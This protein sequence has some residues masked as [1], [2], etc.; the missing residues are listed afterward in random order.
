MFWVD[1]HGVALRALVLARA[2]RAGKLREVAR[3]EQ[4]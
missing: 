2:G 3:W 1:R 4:L